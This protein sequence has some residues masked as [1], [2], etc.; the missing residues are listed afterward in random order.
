MVKN[1]LEVYQQVDKIL[2]TKKHNFKRMLLYIFRSKAKPKRNILDNFFS[3]YDTIICKENNWIGNIIEN[4]NLTN[5]FCNIIENGSD[6]MG[7]IDESDNNA[8]PIQ[9][10]G[11]MDR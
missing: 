11:A 3:S 8:C 1:K 4:R 6:Q 10:E 7:Q 5:N 2:H 9:I